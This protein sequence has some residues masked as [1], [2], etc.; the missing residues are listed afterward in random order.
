MIN[1]YEKLIMIMRKQSSKTASTRLT[2]G[3]MLDGTKC[4][5]GDLKLTKD[6][7]L[8]LNNVSLAKDDIVLIAIVDE[9]YIV[10]GKV[11]EK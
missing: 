7:L 8:Y 10:L 2:T 3:L 5:I 4:Q 1:P 6:D 11:V 9:Q